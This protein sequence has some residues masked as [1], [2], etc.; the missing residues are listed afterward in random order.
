MHQAVAP[1]PSP[2]RV[3]PALTS[4]RAF[5]ALA[6][7]VH[8]TR[9]A[10][11][12]FPVV[13]ALGEVGWLGVPLFFVLSG[14]VLMYGFDR[15]ATWG[16]FIARRIFRIY[17]LHVATLLV[18]LWL[19]ALLGA[20]IGGY[21]GTPGGTV[22]NF[23][24]LHDLTIGAPEIRQAW[25]G[26]SWSLSCEFAFYL[27]APL[28]F[29]ALLANRV[30]VGAIACGA[31]VGVLG[32]AIAAAATDAAGASDFL[33]HHPLP[34]FAEFALG[35]LAAVLVRDGWRFGH[36][37]LGLGLMVVAFAL[38]RDGAQNVQSEATLNYL[39]VPGAL[40]LIASLGARDMAGRASFLHWKPL[41]AAGEASFA[42][43]M[44]HALALPLYKIALLLFAPALLANAWTGE[45]ATLLF[46][47]LAMALASA[48][49]TR[50][51]APAN[52]RLT[53]WLKRMRVAEPPNL[54]AGAMAEN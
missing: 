39:F 3:L 18:S 50:F 40:V 14:F 31:Y 53:A 7:V 10:W 1:T 30:S 17:P 29:R 37:L 11:P 32:A 54:T 12:H 48:I 15:R 16:D 22:L 43:Y 2:P 5:A 25:N 26:V 23:L 33:K 49:H 41:V 27:V 4:L 51:E 47:A 6:V 42:L 44:T 45:I 52:R 24:L 19:F 35:G 46:A 13:R 34:H 38:H 20:P 28:F 8:H 36:P 21:E 9:D